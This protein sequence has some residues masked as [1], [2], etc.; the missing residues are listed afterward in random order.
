MRPRAWL[1]N[2]GGR[3]GVRRGSPVQMRRGDGVRAVP[4][5]CR[6]RI[7]AATGV[8]VPCPQPCLL[9]PRL[10]CG[11]PSESC[12][13]A[14]DSRGGLEARCVIALRIHLRSCPSTSKHSLA[15]CR[16]CSLSSSCCALAASQLKRMVG[17]PVAVEYCGR[18]QNPSAFPVVPF[19]CAD[20]ILYGSMDLRNIRSCLGLEMTENHKPFLVDGLGGKLTLACDLG[21]QEIFRDVSF[22]MKRY[23]FV[24]LGWLM[25]DQACYA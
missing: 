8:V 2:V 16:A 9:R 21:A 1:W 10:L 4:G 12:D 3:G 19:A 14:V 11:T 7:G 25:M 17:Q 13:H 22:F 5:G 24:D 18:M 23:G 15:T 6:A 20:G